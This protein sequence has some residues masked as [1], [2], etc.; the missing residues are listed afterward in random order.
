M[1]SEFDRIFCKTTE[2]Q[3]NKAF[4]YITLGFRDR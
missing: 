2:E 3:L 4:D 1:A